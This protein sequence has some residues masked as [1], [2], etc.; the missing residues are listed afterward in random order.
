M[1]HSPSCSGSLWSPSPAPCGC[2]STPPAGPRSRSR[3]TPSSSSRSWRSSLPPAP[4]RIGVLDDRRAR[5]R[6]SSAPEAPG[7]LRGRGPAVD[8][9]R[10]RG[11]ARR[12][13]ARRS[14]GRRRRVAVLADLRS[15]GRRLAGLHHD[16]H[17]DRRRVDRRA[18]A[19][20]RL[21]RVRLGAPPVRRTGIA[22]VGRRLLPRR[23]RPG[24]RPL[25]STPVALEERPPRAAVPALLRRA[26]DLG[27]LVTAVAGARVARPRRQCGGRCWRWP[28][29][30]SPVRRST[31]GL[32]RAGRMTAR[33]SSGVPETRA[34]GRTPRRCAPPAPRLAGVR[35][36]DARAVV[37]AGCDGFRF[38]RDRGLRPAAGGRAD[39]SSPPRSS[40]CAA[41]RR[42]RSRSSLGFG[43][44][45]VAPA[46]FGMW[47]PSPCA[48]RSSRSSRARWRCSWRGRRS[49]AC[50]CPRSRAPSSRWWPSRSSPSSGRSPKRRR[51]P[52]CFSSS[53]AAFA[54]AFGFVRGAEVSVPQRLSG[55]AA[56][57]AT[58]SAPPAPYAADAAPS[59]SVRPSRPAPPAEVVFA[60]LAPPLSLA[61]ATLSVIPSLDE[62]WVVTVALLLTGALHL[63]R[64]STRTGSPSAEPRDGPP[65]PP[66]RSPAGV[67]SWWA[68]SARSRSSRSRS[69]RCSSAGPPSRCGVGPEW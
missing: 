47:G 22:G 14:G 20:P 57:A 11:V 44:G 41:A 6:R 60:T 37:V 62:P 17:G 12:R 67:R 58:V 61:A 31:R 35:R 24:T 50:G 66:P 68:T 29:S 38:L 32:G 34:A 15:S 5:P 59:A 27:A 28:P 30:A 25:R 10:R 45:L 26:A 36:R 4:G 40:G 3:R 18:A 43:L 42:R 49:A 52:G 51:P 65:S 53:A 13:G 21:R 69:P 54:A 33:T 56:S 9:S 7:R 39:R 64:R 46:L 8:A 48:A 2:A 19:L 16:G 55:A 63:S 23:G 1:R